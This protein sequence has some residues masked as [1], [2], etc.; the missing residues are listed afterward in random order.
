MKCK[1]LIPTAPPSVEVEHGITEALDLNIM[2]LRVSDGSL[3]E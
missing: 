1:L 2:A 3:Y